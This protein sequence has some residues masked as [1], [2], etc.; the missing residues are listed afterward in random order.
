MPATLSKRLSARL[1]LASLALILFAL[2]SIAKE[3]SPPSPKDIVELW[4]Q[5]TPP[6]VVNLTPVVLSPRHTALLVLDIEERTCNSEKRPR[7]VD[8][9][10]AIA[11]LLKKVRDKEMLVVYSLT[12]KGK[13]QT[14]LPAV[15]PL[16]GEPLVQASVDKFFKT[17]LESILHQAGIETVIIVG[18]AAE[19]AVLNTAMAAALRGLKV[20]VVVDGISST[21]LYGEQYTAWHLLNAPGISGKAILTRSDQI[22]FN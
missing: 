8:S 19:G 12:P 17:D 22:R 2:V 9:V 1:I 13:L 6:P 7:C 4:D 3:E 20:V 16:A 18:T 15:E 21:T 10:P 5:V 11:E 14:I